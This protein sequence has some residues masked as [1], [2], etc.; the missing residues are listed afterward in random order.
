[1]LL[2]LEGLK[3]LG[4]IEYNMQ[5]VNMQ[6]SAVNKRYYKMPIIFKVLSNVPKY[7][8][9]LKSWHICFCLVFLTF[10]QGELLIVS[11]LVGCCDKEACF[12]WSHPKVCLI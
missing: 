3:N 4:F 7:K 1:M 9:I 5:Y 12:L 8:E 2:K 10:K 6:Y 11:L